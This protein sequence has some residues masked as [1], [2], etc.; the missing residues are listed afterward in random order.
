[1][2]HPEH[3]LGHG[4]AVAPAVRRVVTRL[5]EH[6]PGRQ[7]HQRARPLA[8][9]VAAGQRRQ[10]ARPIDAVDPRHERMDE[11]ARRTAEH[12]R[13]G[14]RPEQLVGG[15][16]PPGR[17]GPR[18]VDPPEPPLGS[19]GELAAERAQQGR[20]RLAA[21]GDAGEQ[22]QE[23]RGVAGCAEQRQ[24]GVDEQRRQLVGA[25]TGSQP[26][27]ERID[28]VELTALD[29]LAEP[30]RRLV[31]RADRHRCGRWHRIAERRVAL[32]DLG[33]PTARVVAPVGSDVRQQRGTS[34]Q[35]E[36]CMEDERVGGLGTRSGD[37]RGDGA[38]QAHVGG[39]GGVEGGGLGR[40]SGVHGDERRTSS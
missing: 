33:D 20:G 5:V 11:G 12:G 7:P 10:R 32:G 24:Q 19:S 3:G 13:G 37:D 18:L 27:R 6:R 4:Q 38:Q 2:C 34:E 36:R 30:A 16:G 40:G 9:E 15:F 29:R 14:E 31:E 35:L 8:D 1:M 25:G 23:D 21:R 26:R 39:I 28:V 22:P 17:R